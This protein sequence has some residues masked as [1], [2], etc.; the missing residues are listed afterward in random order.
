MQ[1]EIVV[2][3]FTECGFISRVPYLALAKTFEAIE[4]VSAR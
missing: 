2:K 4:D 1:L 3:C